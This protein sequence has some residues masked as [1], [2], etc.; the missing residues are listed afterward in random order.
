[1][2][3]IYP[4]KYK[5]TQHDT[6]L[7]AQLSTES[8]LLLAQPGS[9]VYIILH[10]NNKYRITIGNIQQCTCKPDH[11]TLCIHILYVMNKI[12]RCDTNNILLYQLSLLDIEIDRIITQQYMMPNTQNR[13]NRINTVNDARVIESGDTCC[14]C[15]DDLYSDTRHTKYQL[16]THCH[17][18][19][20]QLHT[21]CILTYSRHYT[22]H[23]S[24]CNDIKKNRTRCPLCR[25]EWKQ[26]IT[27]LQQSMNVFN[28]L[29]RRIVTHKKHTKSMQPV[30]NNSNNHQYNHS[31]KDINVLTISGQALQQHITP[32]PSP[33]QHTE[34]P[35][36][37][38]SLPL[39]TNRLLSEQAPH[40]HNIH[41]RH[42]KTSRVHRGRATLSSSLYNQSSSCNNTIDSLY[43]NAIALH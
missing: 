21:Q 18:C 35:T 31:N 27:Q 25:S 43:I 3:R 16:L 13:A 22:S 41:R 9:C 12:L 37:H 38:Q 36:I 29:H 2:S 23:M 34:L 8:L 30:H 14:I 32:F 26:D 19:K 39:I 7:I 5:P 24:N 20:H 40:L 4:Y 33:S 42:N 6:S 17:T 10:N 15:Y 28:K 1:M 11:S